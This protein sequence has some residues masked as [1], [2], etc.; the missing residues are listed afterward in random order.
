MAVL[1]LEAEL[2][3]ILDKWL[4]TNEKYLGASARRLAEQW[5]SFSKT[6]DTDSDSFMEPLV[7]AWLTDPTPRIALGALLPEASTREPG[8]VH[9]RVCADAGGV[10]ELPGRGQF[11]GNGDEEEVLVRWL[12]RD[13]VLVQRSGQRTDTEVALQSRPVIPGTRSVLAQGAH[14]LLR[15][16]YGLGESGSSVV[17][18]VAPSRAHAE[19]VVEAYSLIARAVPVFHRYLAN[20]VRRVTVHRAGTLNSFATPAAHGAIFLAAQDDEIDVGFAE[21]I[22]HQ[23]GHVLCTTL[24]VDRGVFFATDPSVPF[25]SVTGAPS[26]PRSLYDV[27]HGLFTGAAMILLLDRLLNLDELSARQRSEAIGRLALIATRSASDLANLCQPDFFTDEG[28]YLLAFCRNALAEAATSRRLELRGIDLSNQPYAF[29]YTA[30]A[31]QNPA[32]SA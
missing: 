24:T 21:D 16:F 18:T 13:R 25:S 10:V 32:Y 2:A 6:T 12:D 28:M 15:R 19:H 5:V 23:G 31:S 20:A 27:F 29:S 26:D 30:F 9:M 3:T 22:V 11:A 1:D 17:E 4:P 7:V 14:P 8:S